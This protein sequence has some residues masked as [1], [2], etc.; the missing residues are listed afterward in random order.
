MAFVMYRLQEKATALICVNSM[1]SVVKLATISLNA[2]QPLPIK[3][4]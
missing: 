2:L 4:L 3:N 1:P